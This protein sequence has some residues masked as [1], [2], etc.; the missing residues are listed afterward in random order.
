M[1][2]S[3]VLSSARC[4]PVGQSGKTV[5]SRCQPALPSTDWGALSVPGPI[6]PAYSDRGADGCPTLRQ[7][8]L[9]L[10]APR[11]RRDNFFASAGH[12]L[13]R[14]LCLIGPLFLAVRG[15]LPN[16]QF[17]AY[18]TVAWLCAAR[19]S[20]LPGVRPAVPTDPRLCNPRGFP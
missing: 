9:D 13:T 20:T 12:S 5:R 3:H 14:D 1:V 7:L 8:I 16:P 11:R 4:L 2:P 19:G 17:F 6:A 18:P 15:D 10:P